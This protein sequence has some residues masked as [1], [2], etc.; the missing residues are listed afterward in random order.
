MMENPSDFESRRA[1]G[2]ERILEGAPL[3]IKRFFALDHDV[4]A[5]GAL[6]KRTK[7]L[8]GLTVDVTTYN[9]LHPRL[10]DRILSEER[11]IL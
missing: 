3:A 9:G 4:Y 1:R 6:P 2:N 10:R 5:D 8:L 11:R 7:E